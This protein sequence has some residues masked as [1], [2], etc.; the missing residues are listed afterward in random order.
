MDNVGFIGYSET[1]NFTINSNVNIVLISPA[2]NYSTNTGN[3]NLTYIPNSP[4]DFDLGFCDLYLNYAIY[5][6]HVAL[7][8]GVQDKFVLTGLSSGAY[9][10]YVNCTDSVGKNNIS[11]IR[12]FIIDTQAPIVTTYYPNGE[13]FNN[14]T[15]FFNWTA[16]DN[17]DLILSCSVNINGSIKSSVQ[18]NNNTVV[19]A[20]YSGLTDGLLFWNVSCMDDAG[21]T[22]YS[23]IK[24]FTIQEPPSITLNTPSNN[25]RTKNQNITFY[26][27]PTD[28]SGNISNCSIYLDGLL[29]QTN[30][31]LTAS[32][33]QKNFVISNIAGGY[34]N[35]SVT[36]Y[37]PSGNS[38]NSLTYI[39]YID[40]YPPQIILDMPLDGE[41]L[42]INDVFFNWTA[43]DYAGT[44]INCS[45]YVDEI[46]RN[47]TTQISSSSFNI[48][49]YNL[50]DG[51]HNWSV[52]CTDDLNNSNT[53]PVRYF[54]IN[55][56]DLY[57]DNN[58]I[59][60]NY[61]NPD[62]NNTINITANISNIGGVPANN[63]LIEFWDGIPGIG[64]F[65]G[66]YTATVP[67]NGSVTFWT[68]WN[69]T[70]GYHTVYVLVDPYNNIGELNE[71]NNNATKN[72][73]VL[74]AIINNPL[75]NSMF[76]NQNISLNFTLIDY[77]KDYNGGQINYTIFID[78]IASYTGSGIDNISNQINITLN[79]GL[80]KIN[81]EASDY[82]GRRKNSTSIYVIIDYTAPIPLIN[83]PN[84]TWFNTS[85]PQINISVA[86]NIDSLINYTLY[87]NNGTNTIIG[88]S[89]NISNG[90]SKLINLTSL[91]D[92]IYYLTLEAFDD[93]NN[94]A[95]S[96][97]KTIYIDTIAP[98][99]SLHNPIIG[100]NFNTRTVNFNFTVYD[101][102]ASYAMCNLSIDNVIVTGF[103]ATIGATKNYTAT[104]LSEGT[105]YWNVT[106]RDQA[107]NYNF[108]E[109]RAFNIFI[110][111]SIILINP[112]NNTWTNNEN[113][114]FLF[115]VS[116]ETGIE[117]C[118]IILNGI[119]NQ[120]KN[121]AQIINN[122]TNNFTVES[123]Q[124]G[125]Y[126][127]GIEC[128]DNTSNNAYNVSELRILYV[129]TIYPEPFIETLNNTW[130]NTSNPK[131]TINIT[132]NM[133][134][135]INYTVYIDDIYNSN[136][137][138]QNNTSSNITLAPLNNGLHKMIIEGTDLAGNRRNSTE[139]F[140]YIDTI[141]PTINLISP[142]NNTN[143]T[144]IST[145]LNFTAVDN[146]AEY[147]NCT[148]I[149]DGLP[150][151]NLNVSNNTETSVFVS[152]LVGGYHYWNVTCKDIAGNYNTSMTYRFFVVLPDIY[153]NTSFIYF[154]VASPIEND[155]TNVT[156][157]IR[158]IG[159]NDAYNFTVEIRLGSPT[160]QLLGSFLMNLTVNESKNVTVNYT[161]PIGDTIF[162]VLADV[163]ITANGTVYE[164]DEYNNNASRTITVGSWQYILGYQSGKLAVQ[165][166][167]YSTMFDWVVENATGGN[168]FAADID[169]NI[170][171]FNLT[172]LS[173]DLSNQL[174]PQDFFILDRALGMENNTDNINIT[175]TSSGQP[176]EL[177]NITIFNRQVFNIPSFNSTNNSNFF[178]GILWDSGD[179]GISFN[180]T[181]DV[182]FITKI[183]M[184]ATGY[185]GTYD[186][187][188]RV[189]AKLRE[190]K[191]GTDAVA[192]YA[193][194]N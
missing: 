162:H 176:K 55:Q 8:S 47:H 72:I 178:T 174:M 70:E 158:N 84:N 71:S 160:G 159:Q 146:I 28:N 7:T 105:H 100:E 171:W 41:F 75:N 19:N 20:T 60:F 102:L 83:T 35:W 186:F 76:N 92:G 156:A 40:L 132:D 50:T 184:N 108:S 91:S 45:L 191:G 79:Q 57:I 95:N 9:D 13:I 25:T 124:S 101:N 128:Y 112:L 109:T 134:Q 39:F 15:V 173:R 43:I 85:N 165:D 127:W 23:S 61:T 190:Y 154:T 177:N 129:D 168:I 117:N 126:D 66:N 111:P 145:E 11:E 164:S 27:T 161:L 187:E 42:N 89:G 104:N 93:L 37:D 65:I 49:V 58:R 29:N 179:G 63:V 118:S 82:L 46:Y 139:I 107:L 113:N 1:F 5:E 192:L 38:G 114:T 4:A 52:T 151:I 189:P 150:I 30:T 77:T 94:T 180:A 121:N 21:N 115:N 175:Y 163:P 170:N 103:N 81:V 51:P 17:Y 90:T 48:T 169:S 87:V 141:K 183:N 86:D 182:L 144:S 31:T 185:N 193:E 64:I 98:S 53:T 119:I 120:T 10:W 67:T 125:I 12:T 133:A 140:I 3:V 88:A 26:Y 138:V 68:L 149:L 130:F 14:D 96:T 54:T 32:G 172:A 18:V 148:V 24:N 74:R 73:S 143:L 155:T 135:L 188:L 36:C 6:T 62:I 147:L 22:G 116:D 16:A 137:T 80:R 34:H 44:L 131:I 136:G 142:T 99:V 69:I 166:P 106:C 153:V 110:V 181:Q 157:E 122:A 2:S 194:L 152:S 97:V 59:L 78:N 167:L 33:V 56:P 123:M